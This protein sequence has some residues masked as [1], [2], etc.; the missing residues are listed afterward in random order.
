MGKSL[1]VNVELYE[2]SKDATGKPVLGNRF[3]YSHYTDSNGIVSW[4]L[5]EGTYAVKI[6]DKT[7]FNVSIEPG[8][9]YNINII[10]TI[11]IVLQIGKSTF[12]VNGISNTLDSPPVIKN[13]RTLLPI[14]AIIESLGG[15]VGWDA[16]AKKVTINLGNNTI[17]LWIG[18]NTAKVNGV[19][20]PIDSTNNK[21][22]P[23]IINSRT[24]L[25]LR[26]VTE[27]LGATVNWDGTTQTITIT[28]PGS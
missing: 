20:T 14:R 4:S 16:T 10:K 21:V 22:V 11:V 26:F 12:T 13:S 8:K 19:N 15:T 2:Q 6:E 24:M 1:S 25:P 28:Y 27:N 9:T 5:S 7:V 23:E 17:E 3:S 18:K